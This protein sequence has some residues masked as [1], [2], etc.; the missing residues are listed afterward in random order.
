MAVED[1]H[2]FVDMVNSD[3]DLQHKFRQGWENI[4]KMAHE[5]GLH[6]TREDLQEH[7]RQR[8]GIAKPA[9]ADEKDTCTVCIP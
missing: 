1:A 3:P 5:K 9:T 6:V 2:K 7:L 4:S 8:W